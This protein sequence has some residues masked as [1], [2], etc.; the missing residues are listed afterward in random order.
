MK[1]ALGSHSGG[2]CL[3]LRGLILAP[4]GCRSA[5]ARSDLED[6]APVSWQQVGA[7][8][9]QRL[10]ASS[11][12]FTSGWGHLWP[13]N[14]E[15]SSV[16]CCVVP[17]SGFLFPHLPVRRHWKDGPSGL[18][19]GQSRCSLVLRWDTLGPHWVLA[20]MWP[21]AI[22]REAVDLWMW[23]ALWVQVSDQRWPGRR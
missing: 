11:F 14:Q 5:R 1:V 15:P 20:P 3:V 4:G 17:L 22:Q 8:L 2:V 6:S 12:P 7:E 13:K 21:W 18:C 10:L 16:S 23:Q 19:L 9:A